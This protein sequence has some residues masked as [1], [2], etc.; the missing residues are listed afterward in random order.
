MLEGSRAEIAAAVADCAPGVAPSTLRFFP[1]ATAADAADAVRC[2]VPGAKAGTVAALNAGS[3]GVECFGFRLSGDAL[4]A[5]EAVFAV[6][7]PHAGY[8][9]PLHVSSA[10]VTTLLPATVDAG[11]SGLASSDL[12][13][14]KI[15]AFVEASDAGGAAEDDSPPAVYAS[16]QQL[17]MA[18]VP[19][20]GDDFARLLAAECGKLAAAGAD[21]C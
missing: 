18:A 21:A 3:G 13:S 19:A 6:F 12:A 20:Y 17:L 11:S 10:D 1:V 16:L 15:V 5:G 4:T 14:D 8:F 2:R 9:G 7:S